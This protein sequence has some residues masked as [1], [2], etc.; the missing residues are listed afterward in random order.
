MSPYP[1][2]SPNTNIIIIII[3]TIIIIIIIQRGVRIYPLFPF[4]ASSTS[5]AVGYRCYQFKCDG[6]QIPLSSDK[7]CSYHPAP[8]LQHPVIPYP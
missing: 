1:Y 3:I 6:C 7:T 2:Q 4:S 8:C 5:N